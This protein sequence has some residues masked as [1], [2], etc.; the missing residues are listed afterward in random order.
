[1]S[2]PP[3]STAVGSAKAASGR[4]LQALRELAEALGTPGTVAKVLAEAKV[5]LNEAEVVL[6]RLQMALED[7]MAAA[8]MVPPTVGLNAERLYRD[9]GTAADASAS[10]LERELCR[11][12]RRRWG[13]WVV[14]TVSLV[15]LLVCAPVCEY[16]PV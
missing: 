4:V 14:R 12:R 15:L 8:P 9:L 16:G 7:T 2:S 11:N 3:L 1:M 10:E 5:V 13:L 6:E